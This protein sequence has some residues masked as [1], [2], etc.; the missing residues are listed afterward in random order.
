MDS[1]APLL[2]AR[3]FVYS[4][5]I[6]IAPPSI[7]VRAWLSPHSMLKGRDEYGGR[8]GKRTKGPRASRGSA[9]RAPPRA[10]DALGNADGEG[11]VR[12]SRRCPNNQQSSRGTSSS[13]F[14]LRCGVTFLPGQGFISG[15][16]VHRAQTWAYLPLAFY[17]RLR[18]SESDCFCHE[19]KKDTRRNYNWLTDQQKTE[20]V[21]SMIAQWGLKTSFWAI[22]TLWL[23]LYQCISLLHKGSSSAH[24]DGRQSSTD[25]NGAQAVAIVAAVNMTEAVHNI[26]GSR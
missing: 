17:A 3:G 26:I 18:S 2:V 6:A 22:M 4:D 9:H 7:N 5:C 24:I 25:T 13:S 15:L 12:E 8:S 16:K 20:K 19:T 21:G 14:L 11:S 23:L 10:K 1:H